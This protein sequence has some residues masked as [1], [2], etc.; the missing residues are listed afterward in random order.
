MRVAIVGAGLAGLS[1]AVDLVDA[2]HQVDLYEARPFMGGKVGS[3]EDPDGN[4][5]EMGLHVFFFNYANLFALMRKVGA[6]DNL[7][8]KQH[9][10][11]FVNR[12]GD[13]RDLDFRFPIGAPFNGLK[14]F[15]TTPQLDW[16]DKLRNALA[17]GTSPIVRGLV[18]YEGAMRTIRD[19]DRISFK[20][21]FLSHGGSPRSIERMWDPIA[22]ALGFID[23]QT[24][25]ARCMLTIFMMFAA[26]TEA[27]KL[28][29]LKGSPH[30]WLTGPILD[31]IQQ[32]GG[33]LHLR[34]RVSEVLF[35]EG[36]AGADGQPATRVSGLKLGTPEGEISVE[37]DTYLAAC[38]VPGI[39]RM[40]PTAWRRWPIFDNI[41]RLEAVPV[42]TVQLR[43]DGWV[44]ELGESPAA[45]A[46]RGD[47]GRP[48]G[49]DN[50]L[51]TADADFSCF[52]DLAL[53]SPADYRKQGLGSLLQCVLT[54]GD[55]WIPKKTEEIVAHTDAQVRELFPSSRHLNLV[56]SNVVKLAQSLYREAPGMEPYRPAQRTPVSNFFLAGSYTRQDYI[57]SMEGA[58]MSGRLAAAAILDQPVA[59]A[60]N[61]A[62]ALAPVPA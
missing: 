51:Y 33:R 37:A 56:W 8:P 3:W 26:K 25:S 34:H 24:I 49:L 9:T 4:H 28:N 48:T 1:A 31:Y 32:R 46:A 27:S 14:A 15:F 10:H 53:A 2:G 55:P 58:T 23:C 35:E 52:A 21:W 11:L 39:Q 30:R 20:Q 36:A 41:Y 47:L 60:T 38:D 45:A 54:P 19:L 57:D 13:L 50:L 44:T 62:A 18:D 43:Y 61:A 6:I 17:L 12:G 22:Y 59:L 5:I 7:L 29:L 16:I 40:L 42:A